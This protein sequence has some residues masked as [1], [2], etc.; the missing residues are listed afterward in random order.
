LSVRIR[1]SVGASELPGVLGSDSDTGETSTVHHDGRTIAAL[2]W[3][4]VVDD[5][6]VGALGQSGLNA[7]RVRLSSAI[8][9]RTAFAV[10][11]ERDPEVQSA[12]VIKP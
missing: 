4:L 1:D 7:D 6:A 5:V 10:L 11:A 2:A 8:E 3:I 12:L 9:R